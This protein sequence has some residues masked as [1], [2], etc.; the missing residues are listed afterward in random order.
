MVVSSSSFTMHR[1]TGPALVFF[2]TLVAAGSS[3]MFRSSVLILNQPFDG[4]LVRPDS[5]AFQQLGAE[6]KLLLSQSVGRYLR[7]PHNMPSVEVLRFAPAPTAGALT[8]TCDIKL[9]RADPRDLQRAI[10]SVLDGGRLGRFQVSGQQST[11]TQLGV[12]GAAGPPGCGVLEGGGATEKA[13]EVKG[14]RTAVL[15]AELI[16][17]F[18]FAQLVT[19]YIKDSSMK[20]GRHRLSF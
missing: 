11:F 7:P 13:G 14:G 9:P 3:P 12:A 17:F 18:F 2:L 4:N 19:D 15:W 16:F 5:E 1:G 10:R 8:V 20:L 6:F